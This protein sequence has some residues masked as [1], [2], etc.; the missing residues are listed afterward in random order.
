VTRRL[1]LGAVTALM[2]AWPLQ[3]QETRQYVYDDA[4]QL[5]AVIAPDGSVVMYRFDE[6]GNR[7][8]LTTNPATADSV[9]AILPSEVAAGSTVSVRIV[10]RGLASVYGISFGAPGITATITNPP[11]DALIAASI[12][13]TNSVPAGTYPFT[14]TRSVGAS[15][16]SGRVTLTVGGG[17]VLSNLTPPEVS[18]GQTVENWTLT[19]KRLSSVTAVLFDA[20]GLTATNLASSPDGLSVTAR[21]I[22]SRNAP[23]GTVGVRVQDSAGLSTR[24]HLAI[25]PGSRFLHYGDTVAGAIDTPGEVNLY[26]FNGTVGERVLALV[27]SSPGGIPDLKVRILRPDGTQLCADDAIRDVE[28]QCSLDASG[29]H[30][31]SVENPAGAASGGYGLHFQRIVS[32]GNST[33][34]RFGDTLPGSIAFI[35]ELDAYTFSASAGDSVIARMG[36]TAGVPF[37]PKLRIFRPDGSE[38]CSAQSN[39]YETLMEVFCRVDASGPYTLLAGDRFGVGRSGYG[40]YIQRT[41]APSG[42]IPIGFGDTV[43]GTIN[44]PA[45]RVT[46]SLGAN[47]GD[48]LLIQMGRLP[49][50]SVSPRVKVYRPDGS[51]LCASDGGYPAEALCVLDTTGIHTISAE[52]QLGPGT[53]AYGLHVQRTNAPGHATPIHFGDT[54]P[55]SIGLTAELD[56]YTFSASA[57]DS[58]VARMGLTQTGAQFSPKLR[59][60]RPDGSELCSAQSG[61]Y[62]SLREL[63][64]QLDATGTYALLAGDRFA[65]GTSGYGLH[66]QRTNAPGGALPIGF[67]DTVSGSIAAAAELDAYTFS[68]TPGGQARITMTRV[69]GSLGPK[70]HFY[71]PD[72]TEFCQGN[73]SGSATEA[74]CL[75]D[76]AGTYSILAGDGSGN[77]TGN[78]TLSLQP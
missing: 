38:I 24:V 65:V 41:S 42:A 54:L 12:A 36:L 37:S 57:G 20:G 8:Q 9:T 55:A 75:L 2:V 53:G 60:F 3:A 46:Y 5:I 76:V 29:L 18:Q 59:I 32:P 16:D 77:A 40:L 34:I 66:L 44:F 48:T 1:L 4:G 58:V 17:P 15:I 61:A 25:R 30:T 7:L 70:L 68:G 23:I 43:S 45:A 35:A 11:V 67:G 19:G 21:L 47:R 31:L 39:G 26:S 22:V 69:S 62:E 27:V 6:A 63:F 78:Y 64:C 50:N 51:Q 13:V 71:R 72:G 73:P 10:G 74:L 52:D 49:A 33:P 14:L 56:A 28:I